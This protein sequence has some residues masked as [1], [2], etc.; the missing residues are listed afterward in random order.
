[1]NNQGT[2]ITLFFVGLA[3]VLPAL[4][5]EVAVPVALGMIAAVALTAVAGI[6][7]ILKSIPQGIRNSHRRRRESKNLLLTLSETIAR[8]EKR[9][10]SEQSIR[11]IAELPKEMRNQLLNS[12]ALQH[13]ALREIVRESR[14]LLE[15]DRVS[16]C[17]SLA[18]YSQRVHEL[19]AFCALSRLKTV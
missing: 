12:I 9:I 14:P 3:I 17:E 19:L 13:Q 6:V 7:Y 1:M 10:Q 8:A 18:A 11:S 16:L 15:E 5:H 4:P 2:I